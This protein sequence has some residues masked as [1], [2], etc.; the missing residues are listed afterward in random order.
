MEASNEG[1]HTK[2]APPRDGTLACG[3]CQPPD[4]CGGGGTPNQCGCAP[5][6]CQGA[7]AQCGA[8][9]DGCGSQLDCGSCA[10]PLICGGGGAANVCDCPPATTSCNGQCVSNSC[11]SGQSF[12]PGS[13][14]CVSNGIHVVSASY[15]SGNCGTPAGNVTGA[16]AGGCDGLDACS[17]WSCRSPT[18][19]PCWTA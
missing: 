19:S 18:A 14:T 7:G 15:G 4:T 8:L 9:D 17:I 3:D 6:T 10:P 13:C 2:I 16:V 1:E 11:P 5:R 12:D